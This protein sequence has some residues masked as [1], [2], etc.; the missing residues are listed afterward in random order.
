MIRSSREGKQ[1][2]EPHHFGLH[3]CQWNQMR[4]TLLL[5]SPFELEW[6]LKSCCGIN[7][8]KWISQRQAAT[9]ERTSSLK[10][11]M[12]TAKETR[13]KR[14][15]NSNWRMGDAGNNPY[16]STLKKKTNQFDGTDLRTSR[17]KNIRRKI[18]KLNENRKRNAPT[19]YLL[20]SVVTALPNWER[21]A[22]GR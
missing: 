11:H 22:L 17:K 2:R 15:A 7:S 10:T 18:K 21:W 16:T 3:S 19:H 12:S 4:R 20:H 6:T 5:F 13:A 8:T 1:G 14:S 9:K